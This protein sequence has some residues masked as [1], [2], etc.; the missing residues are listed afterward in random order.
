MQNNCSFLLAKNDKNYVEYMAMCGIF[1]KVRD[2]SSTLCYNVFMV[3]SVYKKTF[4]LFPHENCLSGER[5]FA[6]ITI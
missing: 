1:S 4:R 2:I 6:N 5:C 3:R